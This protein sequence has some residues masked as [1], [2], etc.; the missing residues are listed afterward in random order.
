[1]PGVMW[2]PLYQTPHV[3]D[4][5]LG[6]LGMFKDS[7]VWLQIMQENQMPGASDSPFKPLSIGMWIPFKTGKNPDS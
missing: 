5:V 6:F 7:H 2:I 1:M 4:N 3:Q